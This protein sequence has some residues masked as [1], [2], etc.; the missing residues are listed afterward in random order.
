MTFS[1]SGNIVDI[2]NQKIFPG[3]IYV[4]DGIIREIIPVGSNRNTYIIPGLTDAHIHIESSMLIPSE[5]SR[6]AVRHGTTAT[7]SDPHEIANV[8][9]SKGIKFMQHNSEKVP[10]KFYFGIPSCVPAT[11]FETAGGYIGVEEI[12]KLFQTGKFK[13]LAEMMNFP[14]VIN[15]DRN[16]VRKLELA[17]KF[18]KPVDGHAPGVRGKDLE[19]YVS[20]GISTDHECT[21]I[22][23][24]KE[25]IM[26]GMKVLIR[27]GSAAQN[28][29]S[30]IPL[31]KE[32]PEKIMLCSDDMHP[33]DLEEGHIN[34]LIKKGVELGYD[35]FDLIRAATLNPAMHYNL[36]T[37][38]LRE[39][40]PADMVVVDNLNDMNVLETYIEGMKVFENGKSLIKH[41]RTKEINIFNCKKITINYVKI[42]RKQGKIKVIEAFDGQLFTKRSIVFPVVKEGMITSDLNNDILKIVVYNR[43][44]HERPAISFVKG[45]GLKMGAM[46]ETIAHDSHN[47]IAVGVRDEDIVCVI[48]RIIDLKGGIVVSDGNEMDEIQLNIAGLLTSADGREV[49]KKYKRLNHKINL[50]G[51]SL[52][53]PLMT[54]SFMALLVIPELKI[55]D[56]G[57]F[58]VQKFNFTD[59]F[60]TE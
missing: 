43:Y 41:L 27:E 59:L 32:F 24:G 34:R 11:N 47:I 49:A 4:K 30:L 22:E 8:L 20:Y 19:K 6:L 44:K 25:K 29:N 52:K 26:C 45:F 12:N 46:A 48:N 23:E 39:N 2:F 1:I 36:N 16:I 15:G 21:T 17:E 57:L 50:M 37:G 3:E 54:L 9:G 60:I 18:N 55:S 58:D 53:A 13:F 33:D 7:V 10:F 31:I 38:L 51:S 35:I 5:F 40:D 56:R 42:P 14:G 28:F